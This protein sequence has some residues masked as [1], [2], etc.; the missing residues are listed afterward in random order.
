MSPIPLRSS[1]TAVVVFSCFRAKTKAIFGTSGLA[2]CLFLVM[3]VTPA[4]GATITSADIVGLS[5]SSIGSGNG[6][7]DYILFTGAVG[8]SPNSAGAFNGDDANTDMPKGGSSPT[9][10]ESYVTSFGDLRAFYNLTFPDGSGGSTVNEIAV[11]VDINELGGPGDDISLT[12]FE[13]I[14]NYT[15]SYGDD[16]D[17]PASTDVS[18]ALQNMTNAG[19][20]GGSILASLDSGPKVLAQ[21]HVGAGFADQVIFTGIDPFD[22]AY[23]D[24][25][26]VLFHLVSFDHTNG[27]ET[28]FLSGTIGPQDVIVI[29]EPASIT[30]IGLGL[31]SLGG[32]A[33]SRRRRTV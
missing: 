16:R 5:T 23:A 28:L 29:P 31:V 26:R 19:F 24:G 11:F 27:D 2:A 30:L 21:V 7:L 15:A 13:V 10:D 32:A 4:L 22:G 20:A 1:H 12:T 25:D 6:T 8:G 9:A 18:S 33:W 3:L 14:R 17:D